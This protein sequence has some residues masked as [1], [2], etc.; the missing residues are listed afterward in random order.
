MKGGI[1]AMDK[2]WKF[3]VHGVALLGAIILLGANAVA[4]VV[5]IGPFSA[6]TLITFTGLATGTEVNGLTVSGVLFSYSDGNGNV[7][8]D[9]GPGTT[10][11][12]DPPNI[13]S[14]PGHDKG[15][16]TML[17]PTPAT[18]FGYG[19]AV[20]LLAPDAGATGISVFS[21]TTFL[22]SLTYNGVPDPNYSGG[23]AGIQ[24]TV[25]FDRVEVAFNDLA[26]PEVAFAVDNI[27]I[28]ST[29]EPSTMLLVLSSV[30]GVLSYRRRTMF[31]KG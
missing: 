16:L 31:P 19:W 29:P 18:M 24:S 20:S 5:A 27:R 10:N 7:I 9:G 17:L 21:G 15:T 2:R 11:N 26:M 25:A 8:I 3:L 22:G 6:S 30:I 12:I 23:F 13:V 4:S 28:A 1:G 14:F